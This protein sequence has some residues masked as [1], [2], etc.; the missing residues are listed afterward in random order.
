MLLPF[1]NRY[2]LTKTIRGM[3]YI[4]SSKLAGSTTAPANHTQTGTENL[5]SACILRYYVKQKQEIQE[6]GPFNLVT[7]SS[8]LH[9]I[10]LKLQLL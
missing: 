1:R 3:Q 10:T 5:M 8:A 2:E 9:M 7:R 4:F 6:G